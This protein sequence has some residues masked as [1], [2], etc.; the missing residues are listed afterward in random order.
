MSFI[1]IDVVAR[2]CLLYLFAF[3]VSFWL[4]AR[5][6]TYSQNRIT[7]LTTSRVASQCII[8]PGVSRSNLLSFIEANTIRTSRVFA[9]M[10]ESKLDL[11]TPGKIMY[12]DAT[13]LVVSG[14][15]RFW[16]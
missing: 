10:N 1:S 12:W 7:P 8:L 14:V 11:E 9:S 6:S 5:H 4:G 2:I 15:I 16:E 3:L 13:R